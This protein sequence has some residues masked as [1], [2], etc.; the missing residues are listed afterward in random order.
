MSRGV[1]LRAVTLALAVVHA[2]PASK[3]LAAF[4]GDPS[5]SEG[6]KGIGAALAI[7]LYLLPPKRQARGILRL[8]RRSPLVLTV[9]SS[10]LVLVHAVP[11]SDHLPRLLASPSFGDAWRG[12]GSLAALVWFLL[13]LGWQRRAL[14][15]GLGR[16]AFR[17]AVSSA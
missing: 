9:V 10:L 4:A 1:V 2:F 5:L 15:A 7:A 16:R 14:A 6:W 11:A 8:W 12:I 13:P 3:H 17:P